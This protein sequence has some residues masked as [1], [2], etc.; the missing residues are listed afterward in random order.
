MS[1]KK[2][3]IESSMRVGLFIFGVFLIGIAA[4]FFKVGD[5]I[6]SIIFLIGVIFV[7]A[8]IIYRR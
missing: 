6:G 2:A 8:S 1:L 7:V 3:L 5:W 4:K